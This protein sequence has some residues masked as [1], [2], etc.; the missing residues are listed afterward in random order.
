MRFGHRRRVHGFHSAL[1][2][3]IF[4]H[5]RLY[6]VALLSDSRSVKNQTGSRSRG[7]LLKMPQVS[8]EAHSAESPA[9]RPSLGYISARIENTGPSAPCPPTA[10]AAAWCE[11]LTPTLK[12]VKSVNIVRDSSSLLD[13]PKP[14]HRFATFRCRMVQLPAMNYQNLPRLSSRRGAKTPRLHPSE[15]PEV[16]APCAA[17]RNQRR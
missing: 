11:P 10:M 14:V 5:C 1:A 12:L 6:R 8:Q 17:S 9:N 15:S 13:L 16:L 7:T 2:P 3:V 4:I